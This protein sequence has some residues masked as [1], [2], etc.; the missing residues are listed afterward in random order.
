[1][2]DNGFSLF[3]FKLQSNVHSGQTREA[4]AT[5]TEHPASI[6]SYP[7][8]LSV[9]PPSPRVYARPNAQGI[10]TPIW[11]LSQSWVDY[12]GGEDLYVITLFK[13]VRSM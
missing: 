10:P 11:Q 4:E 13:K 5:F 6:G 1:L 9:Q 2:A 12:D 3:N 8:S 7:P